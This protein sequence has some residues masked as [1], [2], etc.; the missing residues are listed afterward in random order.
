MA[1]VAES[2]D[3]A[4]EVLRRMVEMAGKIK[5]PG[6]VYVPLDTALAILE[7]INPSWAAMVRE[8]PA[9]Q[10]VEAVRVLVGGERVTSGEEPT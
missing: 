3:D 6:V 1:A 9:E 8:L 4:G 5:R 7:Q 2:S 10:Q